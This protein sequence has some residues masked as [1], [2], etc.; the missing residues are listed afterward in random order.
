M[1]FVLS[2]CLAAGLLAPAELLA[3]KKA[4]EEYKKINPPVPYTLWVGGHEYGTEKIQ[5]IFAPKNATKKWRALYDTWFKLVPEREGAEIRIEIRD[6]GFDS[7]PGYETV[8]YITGRLT[9]P[10]VISD[11]PIRGDGT[12]GLFS[13]SNEEL[14]LMGRIVRFMRDSNK[15][16][17][18][19]HSAPA[20]PATSPATSPPAPV[21]APVAAA[22]APATPAA[23]AVAAAPTPLPA[24]GEED[25]PL[26]AYWARFKPGSWVLRKDEGTLT[27]ETKET[28]LSVSSGEIVIEVQRTTKALGARPATR[29]TIPARRKIEKGTAWQEG[30]ETAEIAGKALPCR[31]QRG[32]EMTRWYCSD[33]PGGFARFEWKKDGKFVQRTLAASWEAKP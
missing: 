10:G 31:V 5:K 9:I 22:P 23:I 8:F 11:A 19:A 30:Q 12:V 27:G 25:H 16:G 26:Y 21:A 17:V 20:T 1:R 33:V 29:E 6:T 18:L 28:L 3:D 15:A 24:A 7:K 4:D 14:D 32:A 13:G 2:L